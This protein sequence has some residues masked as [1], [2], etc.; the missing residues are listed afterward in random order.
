MLS[1]LL[2]CT[3]MRGGESWGGGCGR[4]PVQD[5]PVEMSG[6]GSAQCQ[7]GKISWMSPSLAL[8]PSFITSSPA[9]YPAWLPLPCPPKAFPLSLE[10]RWA[11][12]LSC[13]FL[14]L[15]S[16]PCPGLCS[17]TSLWQSLPSVPLQTFYVRELLSVGMEVKIQLEMIKSTGL[18]L[19][20]P[21]DLSSVRH[22]GETS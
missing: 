13:L 9:F 5:L 10:K 12:T 15:L 2:L 16:F 7:Q 4:E 22:E 8:K 20:T 3:D 6:P 14:F 19:S 17:C 11:E 1:P 21:E 18:A